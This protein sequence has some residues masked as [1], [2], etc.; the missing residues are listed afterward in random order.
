VSKVKALYLQKRATTNE[1]T[2]GEPKKEEQKQSNVI[3]D[4]DLIPLELLDMIYNKRIQKLEKKR[5]LIGTLLTESNRVAQ[6]KTRELKIENEKTKKIIE[7]S[8]FVNYLNNRL[9]VKHQETFNSWYKLQIL[10]HSFV[11]TG[12]I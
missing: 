9:E 8:M 2:F 11:T 6:E 7:N 10:F 4:E 12:Q 3:T 1:D 5:Q